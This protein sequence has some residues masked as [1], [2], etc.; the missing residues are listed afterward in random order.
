MR[1]GVCVCVRVTSVTGRGCLP[2]GDCWP[3]TQAFPRQRRV[4]N[5]RGAMTEGRHT[6]TQAGI[7][8]KD[9]CGC[10]RRAPHRHVIN[11]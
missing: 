6:Q 9:G 10:N 1:L 3:R 11:I 8:V 7:K 2:R 5:N 4:V